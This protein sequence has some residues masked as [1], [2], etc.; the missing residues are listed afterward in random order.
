MAK[1]FLSSKTEKILYYGKLKTKLCLAHNVLFSSFTHWS[2]VCCFLYLWYIWRAV[3]FHQHLKLS[4]RILSHKERSRQTAANIKFTSS[5]RWY[6]KSIY[7]STLCPVVW[8]KY[9]RWFCHTKHVKISL[10]RFKRWSWILANWIINYSHFQNKM[11]FFKTF[12]FISDNI[13]CLSKCL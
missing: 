10:L 7:S 12:W 11:Y 13:V 8:F 2:I 4:P 5:N 9:F 1:L 6:I 3:V